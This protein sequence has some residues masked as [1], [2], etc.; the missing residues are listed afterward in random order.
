MNEGRRVSAIAASDMLAQIQK[1]AETEPVIR[2]NY[3]RD[4]VLEGLVS[5]D[6]LC[7]ECTEEKAKMDACPECNGGEVYEG[8][9]DVSSCGRCEG[10]GTLS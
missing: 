1:V 10:T 2:C 4:W 8:E 5:A 3:C 6:G 9:A 7:E